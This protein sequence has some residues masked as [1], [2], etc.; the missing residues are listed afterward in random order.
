MKQTNLFPPRMR[1]ALRLDD[2]I[3]NRNP[4]SLPFG[5]TSGILRKLGTRT[6]FHPECGRKCLGESG[7]VSNQAYDLL[8]LLEI[9]FQKDIFKK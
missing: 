1:A 4:T 7:P 5:T 2:D 9:S 6:R 3:G 8:T